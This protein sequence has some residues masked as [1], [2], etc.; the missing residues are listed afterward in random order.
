MDS[1]SI[2]SKD[3]PGEAGVITSRSRCW[4]TPF[5][6]NSVEERDSSLTLP[7]LRRLLQSCLSCWLY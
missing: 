3:T 6:S 5:S 2:T 7:R 1:G 4:P